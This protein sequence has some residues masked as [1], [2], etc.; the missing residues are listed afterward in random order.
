MEQYREKIICMLE[1]YRC[2]LLKGSISSGYLSLLGAHFSSKSLHVLLCSFPVDIYFSLDGSWGEGRVLARDGEENFFLYDWVERKTIEKKDHSFRAAELLKR[3]ASYVPVVLRNFDK[4]IYSSSGSFSIDKDGGVICGCFDNLVFFKARR[5]PEIS[6]FDLHSGKLM[7]TSTIKG[8]PKFLYNGKVFFFETGNTSFMTLIDVKTGAV[9]YE[10]TLEFSSSWGRLID[11]QILAGG[12][13]DGE[14]FM[15]TFDV[16]TGD[17]QHLSH[18]GLNEYGN[19]ATLEYCDSH[20]YRV[21]NSP[22]YDPFKQFNPKLEDRNV[23]I[24][25]YD[26]PGLAFKGKIE[27]PQLA[28]LRFMGKDPTTKKYYAAG[29]SK[30]H[31]YEQ[32]LY[33]VTWDE[34]DFTAGSKEVFVEELKIDVSRGKDGDKTFYTVTTGRFDTFFELFRQLSSGVFELV[35]ETARKFDADNCKFD[36]EFNGIVYCDLK[37]AHLDKK[38]KVAIENMA[39]HLEY[40]FADYAHFDSGNWIRSPIKIVPLFS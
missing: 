4:I 27:F 3:G 26:L 39:E 16:A 19:I 20:C 17:W 37:N 18:Y 13:K 40:E 14:N 32:K 36:K 24:E 1:M 25:R 8:R 33:L 15:Y 11:G 6:A 5:R 30:G 38:E 21:Y 34:S 28:K 35:M 22:D 10:K 2:E 9:I 23:T 31:L 7:W 12:Y 29:T